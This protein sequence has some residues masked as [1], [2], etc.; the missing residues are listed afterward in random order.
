VLPELE[1]TSAAL[2][3]N[4]R[5]WQALDDILP[6]GDSDAMVCFS[7]F[8]LVKNH[9]KIYRQFLLAVLLKNQ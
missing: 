7:V 8:L 2:V 9:K 5:C 3:H 4:R 6:P 1:P